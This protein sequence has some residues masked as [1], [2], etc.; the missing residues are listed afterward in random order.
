MHYSSVLKVVGILFSMFGIS[1]IPPTAI[2]YFTQDGSLT[3]FFISFFVIFTIGVVI[4]FP[5]RDKPTQLGPR[6]GFLTVAAYWISLAVAGTLPFLLS[7][8]LHIGFTDA[9]FESMSGLTTTGATV[10]T[11]L[12]DLP[13]SV[14]YYRQ[15]LQ[16]LGGMGI[17][18]LAVAV[19]PMLGIGGMQLYRAEMPGTFRNTKLTPR[20]KETA[21]ALWYI[22]LGLTV[23]CAL[24][25][26]LAG[27]TPFDAVSHSFSTIAIGGFSTHDESFAYF[28]GDAV[29]YIAIIF[30]I[31]SGINFALHFRILSR[32]SIG[33]LY[34]KFRARLRR[35]RKRRSP[36]TH[37][38][39]V[40]ESGI[41]LYLQDTEVITYLS[42]ILITSLTVAVVLVMTADADADVRTAIKDGIFQAVSIATTSGFTTAEFS[43]WPLFLPALLLAASIIGGCTGSTAGGVKVFRIVLLFKQGRR[44]IQQLIHPDAI[45]PIQLKNSPV[46]DHVIN[47]V[48]GFFVLYVV[49][50]VVLALVLLAT[51]LDM[52]TAYST[53]TAC[54]NN[55]GPALGQAADNY[56][57]LPVA[58]KWVLAFTMLLGRLE[59]FTLL[60]LLTPRYWLD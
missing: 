59:L 56:A 11:G 30:M 31:L 54:L 49:S 27:M 32:S 22:Y 58:A 13:K 36:A 4:W 5:A 42:L 43:S 45:F 44:E 2:S 34:A 60:I 33:R 6:E 3:A 38:K 51:G 50:F 19:I 29:L 20:I 46:P 55:L 41:R 35:G 12:D 14:L 26:W 52:V 40:K 15:Q 9:F 21:K 8:D 18:V 7:E 48:W 39:Q 28:E 1:L 47:A 23:I 37:S 24:A 17:I 53:V 10:L 16:W 57:S 25:Y